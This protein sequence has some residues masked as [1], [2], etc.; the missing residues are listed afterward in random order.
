MDKNQ[1]IGISLISVLM[2]GYFGFMSTQTPET[3]VA[4]PPAITQPVQSDTVLLKSA[5]TD[6]ALKAQNQREYGDF[7]AAMV[8]EAKEYKLENKDVVVTLSTKGG[9]IKSV[10]LKNYFTWDKK[11]L[12]LFK[13]ENNQLSLILNTNKKPVDLY[14]LYYAGVESKAG[15]K[16]VVTFKT[17]AGNGKTIEH[18]YTL[19]AAGFTVD[20]NLKAAGFGGELPNLPLTLDWREQVERIEYDSEQARVKS[21]VN[22]MAAE[23]GFD[24]LSEA[25]K[26]RETETLS[27]VYWVSLKQK[28]FNSGFYIREGGTIPSATVTAYP[29]YSTLPNAPVNS[30][31]FIKALEAQVQLPLEA[32]ISGKAAYAF[33]FGPNDFKIC[34]AVPAENY[35]KNVNLG[36]PLVSWINRFVVIPVF[37]GLK[38]VFSSFGL[39][40]VIL[41]LLIKLVL[42]PLSYKSFVSMA[43]MKALKPELD[44]LKAKHGDDQ[45]AI[46]M[47]QMQ[48]YKQFGIN[49][50]SGCIPV[51]LQMPILLAMFNF[52][53]NAID[54]RGESL[55][56]ATDLSS[57][58][59]FAKLP[60]TIPFYGSHVSMF[61]LLMTIS[62][63]A[64]TWVNNQVSTVT[65][66][67]KYMSYAMPV[68]FLF[69]LNSFPAGLSFYYFVSNLVTIAQQLIIRRFVDEGQLRLQL[70]AKRDKNLSG[71]TTGGAPK[72]NRFM[73]RMEEAMKQREQEQQF[74]KN[75]KKK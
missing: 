67:M 27:N 66:P 39:I 49:P 34:K 33:Y 75:I 16:Q 48:V 8:G 74:K 7:A 11:Q 45:Q 23:D 5:A 19:G 71:D 6:T 2:L 24:Y 21:T 44:E 35:Q 47:E 32:V 53:P 14:S 38:G 59:E 4:T 28:F 17:D 50:L 73:A 12:F 55:W 58:D 9:T 15:D 54:L 31:K 43:K 13:Q 64:Y 26:D 60:F 56:W 3:P 62:T 46:Q 37:D 10:L 25:S 52:F 22:Y 42:L 30:E 69:V 57:Y 20:Y 72:K 63:L 51:L 36:W 1:I 61:T 70:E 65:G 68:V 41:V 29:M 18:T 40:I